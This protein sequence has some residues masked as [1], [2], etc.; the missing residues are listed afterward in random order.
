MESSYAGVA[1]MYSLGFGNKVKT[2]S[3]FTETNR[4]VSILEE[5]KKSMVQTTQFLKVVTG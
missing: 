5:Q 3:G 4:E 1:D 2:K